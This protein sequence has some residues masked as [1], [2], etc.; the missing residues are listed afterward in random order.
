MGVRGSDSIIVDQKIHTEAELEDIQT[1][2]Q[3]EFKMQFNF[4]EPQAG[5]KPKH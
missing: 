3:I 1:N 4:R 5:S 2:G